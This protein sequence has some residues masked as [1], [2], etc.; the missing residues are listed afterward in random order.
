M[1]LVW[2]GCG[3]VWFWYMVGVVYYNLPLCSLSRAAHV[4]EVPALGSGDHGCA[5][6]GLHRSHCGTGL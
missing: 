5:A 3:P 6:G 2:V 4:H 1:E